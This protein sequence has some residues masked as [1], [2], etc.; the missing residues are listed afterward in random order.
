VIGP[1]SPKVGDPRVERIKA[2]NER[3][4]E[5]NESIRD[6][7]DAVG[8]DMQRIPFL[9]ECPIESCVE[10]VRLTRAEYA[11]VREHPRHFVTAVGHEQAEAPAA[12]VVAR[13]DGYV[14]VEKYGNGRA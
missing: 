3:F 6:R 9:C 14:I 4:R 13:N 7:A 10:I 5:A 1:K 11:M 12:E 2:N 8:A